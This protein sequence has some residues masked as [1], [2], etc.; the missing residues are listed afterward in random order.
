MKAFGI[1]I[2][3][4][5][6]MEL[7]ARLKNAKDALE[8]NIVLCEISGIVDFFSTA[9]LEEW[10]E[11]CLH[12]C[13]EFNDSDR[14]EY[15]DFQTNRVLA[16]KVCKQLKDKNIS[17]DIIVEP[18]FGKGNFILAALETFSMV[19][20]IIGVEIY[21]PYVWQTKFSILEFFLQNPH[22]KKPEIRLLHQNVF[23]FDFFQIQ[24]KGQFILVLGNPPWVTNAMLSSLNSGNLPPKSNFK[25]HAGFDAITGKGNFDIGEYISLMLVKAFHKNPGAIA[26][27]VKN[28]VIKNLL[29][30]QIDN[31]YLLSNIEQYLINASKEFGASVE[32]ALLFAAFGLNCE[33]HC[34]EYDFYSR[35]Q[36]RKFGWSAGCFVADIDLYQT[37][38]SLEGV[39]PIEWR[40]G[41]KHDCSK[42]ME[43]EAENGHFLNGR[44]EVVE[45]ENELVYGVLKSSDLK[46]Q[47]VAQSRKFTI[48]TQKKIGQETNSIQFQH[49]KTWQYLLKNEQDFENRKSSIYKGKPAFSI[50][51]VGNYSFALFKVA[52]SGLYKT[53]AFSLVLPATGKPLMLDDT[54]YFIGFENYAD[55]VFTFA[56]LNSKPVQDFLNAIVFWDSKRAITKDILMRIDLAKAVNCL[57]FSGMLKSLE[58]FSSI[59]N[60]QLT[61]E[62]WQSFQA[63]LQPKKQEQLV[64]F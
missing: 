14:A 63:S 6:K 11:A 10:K 41:I 2:S 18:T 49:P 13:E 58:P 48:V 21:K 64:L 25:N 5:L 8:A 35:L 19:R 42:I 57:N 31:N 32:A 22:Q 62:A 61:L 51:G 47:V 60:S 23:D 52:I 30:D 50:F 3:D 45:L 56:A 46:G 59:D 4:Y 27:L 33:S 16:L 26:F 43:L 29:F 28:S 53:S 36:T 40:Q 12:Q 1:Y 20:Q 9:D 17:P 34:I 15:G 44:N 24:G 54:C 38:S 37:S 55:A 7:S 39:C